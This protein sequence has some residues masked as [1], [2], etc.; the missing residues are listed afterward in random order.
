MIYTSTAFVPETMNEAFVLRD[1]GRLLR[2]VITLLKVVRND[3]VYAWLAHEYKECGRRVR[4]KNKS[5]ARSTIIHYLRTGVLLDKAPRT[6]KYRAQVK[7]RDN[8]VTLGYYDT[9]E[10]RDAAISAYYVIESRTRRK[11][12]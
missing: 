10:A 2:N 6:P 5:Y 4:F 3:V 8:M 12:N 7:I 9:K 11:S 1:G